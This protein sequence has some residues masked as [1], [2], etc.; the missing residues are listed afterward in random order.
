MLPDESHSNAILRQ[1]PRTFRSCQDSRHCRFIYFFRSTPKQPRSPRPI[2]RQSI[3]KPPRETGREFHHRQSTFRK[4][5]VQE[6]RPHSSDILPEYF[7]S[8][9]SPEDLEMKR[10]SLRIHHTFPRS[11][12]KQIFSLPLLSI[13]RTRV[14]SARIFRRISIRRLFRELPRS[15][16]KLFQLYQIPKKI[17]EG[18]FQIPSG[19]RSIFRKKTPRQYRAFAST[20]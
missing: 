1:V 7:R 5:E 6:P 18:T 16:L 3:S 8:L 20:V 4:Y 15:A 11:R 12:E 19:K 17:K 10:N 13:S 2:H 14:R 9:R